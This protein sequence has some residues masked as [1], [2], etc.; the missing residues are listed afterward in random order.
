M[1]CKLPLLIACVKAC[2]AF[3]YSFKSTKLNYVCILQLKAFS[4]VFLCAYSTS[5]FAFEYYLCL[6]YG[7]AEL[8]VLHSLSLKLYMSLGMDSTEAQVFILHY[9]AAMKLDFKSLD[10]VGLSLDVLNQK[11]KAFNRPVWINADV[12][13]GPNTPGFV[14]P[15]NGTR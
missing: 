10:S 12:L 15:L 11:N 9:P 7:S 2:L 8:D 5:C 14:S 1:H 6:K 4:F 3:P 13:L